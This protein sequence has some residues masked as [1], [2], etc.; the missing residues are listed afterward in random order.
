MACAA[1]ALSALG[2]YAKTRALSRELSDLRAELDGR[3]LTETTARGG[4]A[5]G[6]AKREPW[7]DSD[8]KQA[9]AALTSVSPWGAA[10]R[11]E[12]GKGHG[13][14]KD[15]ALAHLLCRDA[16]SM[17]QCL[18]TRHR[19]SPLSLTRE[20]KTTVRRIALWYGRESLLY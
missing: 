20:H 5:L 19:T 3:R 4:C 7:S 11:S 15:T 9:L 18:A 17:E 8:R 14:G 10:R 16:P 12:R 6:A 13:S 2:L 1:L